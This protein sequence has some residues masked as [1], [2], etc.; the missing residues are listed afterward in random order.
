[1]GSWFLRITNFT[2]I[3]NGLLEMGSMMI[4]RADRKV[5]YGLHLRHSLWLLEESLFAKVSA[6]TTRLS[7]R[8]RARGKC[9]KRKLKGG[10]L[11]PTDSITQT[12]W[13]WMGRWHLE[14]NRRLEEAEGV[15]SIKLELLMESKLKAVKASIWCR[16]LVNKGSVNARGGTRGCNKLVVHISK[17]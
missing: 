17:R 1:M 2:W 5:I 15:I 4:L 3:L 8:V 6:C 13:A 14:A 16:L 12:E 11:P 9:L 7:G 10:I